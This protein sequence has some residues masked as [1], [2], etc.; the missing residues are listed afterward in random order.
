MCKTDMV[1]TLN[2]VLSGQGANHRKVNKQKVRKL[3]IVKSS[4]KKGKQPGKIAVKRK[5]CD[6]YM[7]GQRRL[8]QQPGGRCAWVGWVWGAFWE[9]GTTSTR[10]EVW[11]GLSVFWEQQEGQKGWSQ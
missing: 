6:T 8:P 9:A 10:A 2:T 7:G 5:D 11:K 3:Q 1:F 4:F